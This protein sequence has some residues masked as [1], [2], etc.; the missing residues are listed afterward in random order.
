LNHK[1]YTL[2]IVEDAPTDRELYRRLLLKDPNCDYDLLEAESVV[3]GLE[4][5]QTRAIDAI[6]LD[7]QLPDGDGLEFLAALAAQSGGKLPPVVMLTGQGDETIAV[8][9]MK[10]GAQDYLVKRDLTPE[11][12][13]LSIRNAISSDRF[14]QQLAQSE[15]RFRASIDNMLDCV[16][17]YSAIRTDSGQISDFRIDYHNPAALASS[18]LTTADIGK[19]LCDLFPGVRATGLLAE[20][21]QVVETGT[22]L[23]KED[24]IYTDVFGGE[25]L[26]RVY[27]LQFSKL[28]DGLI[29][30]WRDVTERKQIERAR[31]AAENERDRFFNLSIDLLAI[32]NFDDYFTRLNPAFERILGFTTAELMAQPFLDFVHPD[33]R[34]TT[35]VATQQ[36]SSGE[37]LVS[38]ENRY[39][40]QDGSYRW[41]LWSATPDLE[42]NLIYAIA[43][44]ITNR[45][46]LELARLEAENER[47]RFF[48]LSIDLLAIGSFDGYFTRINPAFEQTLGFTTAELM[49]EPFINFVHPDDRAGTIAGATSL[50]TGASLVNHDNRYRC[51]DGSYRWISW[52]ATPHAPSQVWYASGQDITDRKRAERDLR[53]S[54][55]RLRTGIE[56]AGVGLARFDYDTNLVALS[57]EAAVLYGFAPDIAFVM[58]EQIHATFHPDERAQLEAI[59]AQV[60]DPTGTGWFAQDHRV[61]LP[62]GEVR[63]LSVRKQVFFVG[64]GAV[65]RPSYA[66]LAAID[67]TALKQTEAA[68]RSS[69][70]KFA[71]IFD[72]TFE[73]LGLLSL[74][75]TLL[76]V[77]QTALK[78]LAQHLP[79]T[80]AARQ[81][82]IVGQSFWETPW[83]NHSPLLQ[84][85]LQQSIALA[86][87]GE[88]IRYEM[89]Y[90]NPSGDMVDLDFTL[91]PVFDETGRVV[92]ILAEGHDITER[93]R[94]QAD[95]Q[96]RNQELDSFVHVVSHDLKAPLRAVANLSQ[97]IEED[98]EGSLTTAN[99]EQMT[100][101]RSRIYR[102]EATIDGLLDYV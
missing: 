20:Y 91:Q 17:I 56:V 65:A 77:N 6:L 47:D 28:R 84:A 66:I 101:L 64:D 36:L 99:Q 29:C 74:D 48:N 75:G 14:R 76:E 63:C 87:S 68:L 41:L 34:A 7:Y 1:T 24:L 32:A 46:Q 60:V 50:A 95:L 58:R 96:N 79:G 4:F 16:G 81:S 25:L 83:W 72:Q 43:H 90:P 86:A 38:F 78:S 2:L 97:W 67:I 100:L 12:L 98:L 94:S 61:V 11:L 23:F 92:T 51:K 5:C 39:R 82:A 70:R 69:E 18:R 85:K 59:I 93:Q 102:M 89:Q 8:Q 62:S 33:D 15:D 57:P 27:D 35:V 9:A 44:D 22:P 71:A 54:Q 52:T 10:L 19:R 88:F 31:I 3:E 73:L 40:C 42:Q 80:M 13:Q 55:E 45:K 21:T 53:E 37:V 49:A 26:T 30:A